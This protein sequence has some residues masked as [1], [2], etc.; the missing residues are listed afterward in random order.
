MIERLTLLM[1]PPSVSVIIPTYNRGAAIASTIDSVL[2]QSIV[3]EVEIIVIDDGSTDDTLTFLQIEYS[4]YAQIQIISQQNAGVAAARN[5]GLKEAQGEYIA[6]LDH[7]DIWLPSKLEKQRQVF[8]KRPEV[9]VVYSHWQDFTGEQTTN[10][11]DNSALVRKTPVGNV[12]RQL[13]QWN[14]IVSMSV[15]LVRTSLLREVGGFDAAVAPNDDWDLWLR[16][17]RKTSFECVPETLVWYRRHAA[18]QSQT[19]AQMFATTTK[20]LRKQIA[21]VRKNP[22]L[23]WRIHTSCA[24]ADSRPLYVQAKNALFQRQWRR[25]CKALAQ[26]FLKHPLCLGSNEWLYFIKRLLTRDARPY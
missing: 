13:L 20:V 6:F 18:Q 23:L 10:T 11:I 16:L 5:R 17:A 19:S 4:K 1:K 3:D 14:F 2:A 22:T 25:A 26:A 21:V 24:F 7:D 15:P 8:Q 9:G 12:Y